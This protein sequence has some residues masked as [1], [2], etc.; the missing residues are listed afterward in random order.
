MLREILDQTTERVGR[1]LKDQPEVEATLR[2]TIGLTYFELGDYAKAEATLREAL[3]INESGSVNGE[4]N[5]AVAECLQRL[6]SV[7]YRRGDFAG[8]EVLL[9]Q[10]LALET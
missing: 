7:L 9:R 3:R 2:S 6:A 4:A 10:Q 8:A 1:D 5:A